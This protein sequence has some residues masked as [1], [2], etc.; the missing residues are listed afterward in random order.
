M[1]KRRR[2]AA[3]VFG[4]EEAAGLLHDYDYRADEHFR[5]LDAM[6]EK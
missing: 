5:M 3:A 1:K 4:L 6:E 2:L